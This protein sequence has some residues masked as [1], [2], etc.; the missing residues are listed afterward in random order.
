MTPRQWLRAAWTWLVW[1]IACP[2][3][4]RNPLSRKG[5][6][7]PVAAMLPEEEAP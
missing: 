5:S 6:E 7:G 4:T 1:R 2:L 3:V